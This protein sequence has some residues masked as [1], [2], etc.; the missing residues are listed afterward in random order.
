RDVDTLYGPLS[1]YFN[2][3]IFRIFG[4]GIMVLVTANLVVYAAIVGVLY[5]L[6]R[7]AWGAGAALIASAIFVSVF[8]FS[9]FIH[10]GNLN[11]ATP[12]AHEATHG[13][14]VALLL[15]LVLLR[16]MERPTP[17]LSFLAGALF[18]LTFVLKPEFVLSG[19]LMTL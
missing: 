15:A 18:G 10:F 8:S 14:L 4:P 2:A 5:C 12:Y 6:C 16:W 1:Q 11:Y 7:R 13:L 17:G 9:Q 19:G 3:L